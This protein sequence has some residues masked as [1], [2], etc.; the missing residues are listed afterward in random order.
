[1]DPEGYTWDKGGW[2]QTGR[3]YYDPAAA[4]PTVASWKPYNAS[5]TMTHGYAEVPLEVKQ[6]GFELVETTMATPVSNVSQMST[7]AGYRITLSSPPGFNLTEGQ[8]KVLAPY[9]LFGVT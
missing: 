6:V 8:Q 9:R 5:V 1:M 7:P 4:W 3:F 2:I